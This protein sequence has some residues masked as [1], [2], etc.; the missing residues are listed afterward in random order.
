MA[1]DFTYT[2]DSII[3]RL[4]PTRTGMLTR[5]LPKRTQDFNQISLKD[6]KLAFA[7]AD[8]RALA[9]EKNEELL[10]EGDQITMSHRLAASV[11]SETAA[12][13]G[14]PPLTDLTLRTD[15]EGVLG[16]QGFRL[17]HQW[18]RSG[19][20]RM[21]KR[22]G[23]VLETDK[24]LQRLPLW[25]MEAVDVAEGFKQSTDDAAHWE[26]LA[27]FRKALEPG[28]VMAGDSPDARVSMTDFLSGLEVSL[29]DSFSISPDQT[30]DDFDVVPF[31]SDR[32]EEQSSTTEAMAELNGSE[33]LE[34]QRKFR[35]RGALNAFSL[36][37]RRFLVVDRSAAPALKTMAKMQKAGSEERRAFI[38]NP[39]AKISE[40]VEAHL[41]QQGDFDA[42][43]PIAQEEVLE[44]A[45]ETV[46]IETEEYI[47]FSD[48][49]TGI[50]VYQGNAVAEFISS[51]TTW[52]P[53]VF[54]P[55]VLERLSQLTLDQLQSARE[56]VQAAIE[57]GNDS[58]DFEGIQL[59]ANAQTIQT[60]A[61][62]IE[63][64][65]KKATSA[66]NSSTPEGESDEGLEKSGP[67]ILKTADNFK[68]VMWHPSRGP[69]VSELGTIVPT[70]IE[71]RLKEHQVESLSW[72]IAAWKSGLPGVLNAD[73]QGLGKT[74]QT[75]AFLVWLND[76][77]KRQ[78][79]E[80]R[81]PVLVVAPT[82]LLENWEQ[83][84]S[85]HVASPG[86]GHLIRLYGSATAARRIG[87]GGKDV[88]TG[89]ARLDFSDIEREIAAQRGHLT[90]V[91][92][93]YTTLT[94][95]QHSL[96]KIPFVAAVFDEI[97]NIKNP[98][99]L[100]ANAARAM[101]VDFRIGLTGTPIENTTVDLWAIMD[102]LAPGALGSLEEFRANYGVADE[103][104]M[105]ELYRRVFESSD[106]LPPL[107]L[108][109]LKEMVA[110]DLPTKSRFLHP[111]AM[112]SLQADRYEEARAKLARG[113]PG[114]AL[115]MLHHIRTVSVH[116]ALD[117]KLDDSEFISIS[118]RLSA[119]FDILRRI[120]A[121][122]ERALVFIESRKMQYR[123]IELVRAEFGL[124][125][126]DLINGETAIQKRQ[127]IVNRFQKHLE[128]D[129]GFDLLVLGPKAAGTGLTLTA[130]THVIHLSR[131]WNPAVEEQCNDRIH[132]MGQMRS[133]SVHVPLAIHPSYREQSFDLLLQSL[134]QRKRRLA[135][136]ALWPMGDTEG[137]AS[138]LQ[139]MLKGEA[140][141]SHGDVVETSMLALFERDRLA[142]S[143]PD[144]FG[145]WEYS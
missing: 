134:M 10:I 30:G 65:Q 121:A 141:S 84:V 143:K 20:Q 109:R 58:F 28:V 8:L 22:A 79:V 124:T 12:Q 32:L 135:T 116:P 87:P 49:V 99:T 119:T 129:G 81:G 40:A 110:R 54:T 31:L 1:F 122:N 13:I 39:R 91:L 144:G 61:G 7:V 16:S 29:S 56:N 9:D 66:V 71:T 118:G 112:P 145:A 128:T 70:A 130:A 77:M 98:G 86:L 90:W 127:A 88:E 120:Q 138:Q 75:I 17:R 140:E 139:N 68:E 83:E 27:R 5:I 64:W 60:L 53:E 42:L 15:A 126:V 33:L 44:T 123:F 132:R 37:P 69:R 24:G 14:L 115:K 78:G 94:Y 82:S 117:D 38:R 95:Y 101:N 35:E 133:V 2:D 43:E 113:K 25:M 62:K 96:G 59:P 46:F 11:D 80:Q 72:Q 51:G 93:T 104:N 74:L 63:E 142:I 106:S 136:A 111:R 48:R 4:Q 76:H 50:D 52:L 73:E 103:E 97:Q 57:A 41:R 102:Q 89:Q 47:R 34:F 18:M 3:L 19:Q 85:R 107:A 92:T 6:R 137:D 114:G 108:R 23:A 36:G 105:S 26:S 67:V 55:E 131:W 45:A 100:S 125:Q 21:P